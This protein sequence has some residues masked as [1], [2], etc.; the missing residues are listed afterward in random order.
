MMEPYHKIGFYSTVGSVS[1]LRMLKS[2][3]LE[4]FS[5]L[6][7]I[8]CVFYL[9]YLQFMIGFLDYSL[10]S[11]VICIYLERKEILYF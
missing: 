11:V 3:Y 1:V 2:D 7:Y 8:K 5:R 9:Q 4:M 10:K 6:R